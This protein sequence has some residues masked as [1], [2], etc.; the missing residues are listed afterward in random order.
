MKQERLLGIT[1]YLLARRTSTAAEL[2][3]RFG[4]SARTI[5]RD[6]DALSAAGVP[7]YCSRGTGG[8]I[9][10]VA[11]YTLPRLPM[12]EQ[13]REALF[14]AVS[15]L[16]ATRH[17]H[18]ATALEKLRARWTQ[19]PEPDWVQ[20]NFAGYDSPPGD[21][22]A[23]ALI[24]RSILEGRPLAFDYFSMKAERTHRVIEP[25]KL[26]FQGHAWYVFGYCRERQDYRIFKA[27]RMGNLHLLDEAF[28]PRRAMT[29][30]EFNKRSHAQEDRAPVRLH[31]R[32]QPRAKYRVLDMFAPERIHENED[33]TMDV[34][35]V[36]LEDEWVYGT[37]LSFGG[38]VEVLEPADM[39]RRIA[40]R[41][42]Q[43][44]RHYQDVD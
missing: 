6:L 44:A 16:A 11:D 39:R 22:E 33:G 17:P 24:R 13:E 14:M 34:R 32:F 21:T 18:A 28:T 41:I 3:D 43:A 8:G 12:Q 25:E 20:I 42:R 40:E 30:E 29:Y 4:V 15:E 35:C 7:V 23:F 31:L 26:I 38:D 1:T 5:Y 36:F 19:T 9:S 10:L 27:L 37:L 2:A